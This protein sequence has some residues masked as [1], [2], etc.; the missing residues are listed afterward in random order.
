MHTASRG[1][2]RASYRP[3]GRNSTVFPKLTDRINTQIVYLEAKD[4]QSHGPGHRAIR[5]II[6]RDRNGPFCPGSD[7]TK[8]RPPRSMGGDRNVVQNV[9]TVE[10]RI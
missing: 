4:N 8:P 9:S 3:S 5:Q 1:T 2:S 7:L 10:I 6:R